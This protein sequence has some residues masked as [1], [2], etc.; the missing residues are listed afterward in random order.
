MVNKLSRICGIISRL[1][2]C[3]SV[4]LENNLQFTISSSPKLWNYSLGFKCRTTKNPKL[5]Q[6]HVSITGQY[7]NKTKKNHVS[8]TG[9]YNNKTKKNHVSI[10]GQYNNK[11]KKNHVSITGQYNNKTKKNHVSITGQYN[12][13]TKGQGEPH[14]SITGQYNNKTK[15]NHMG[16][17]IF[18]INM[19]NNLSN[20]NYYDI[21]VKHTNSMYCH[22]FVGKKIPKI[23]LQKIN[24]HSYQGFINYARKYIISKY[25]FVIPNCCIC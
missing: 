18:H 9:Q 2:H 10:T 23:V 24:S 17:S 15:K 8:I 4:H 16:T 5:F 6:I 21:Q 1:K 19:E 7:N 3:A 22:L 25:E 13:K 20:Y 12:N 14:V 11:T